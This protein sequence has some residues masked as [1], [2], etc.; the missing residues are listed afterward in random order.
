MYLETILRAV[1]VR[2]HVSRQC[3]IRV[4][5]VTTSAYRRTKS[6]S[7]ANE[8][9]SLNHIT[10]A[11]L[12]ILSEGLRRRARISSLTITAMVEVR[13]HTLTYN[14]GQVWLTAIQAVMAI[15]RQISEYEVE[16]TRLAEDSVAYLQSLG[17]PDVNVEAEFNAIL[18]V[19]KLLLRFGKQNTDW[20]HRLVLGQSIDVSVMSKITCLWRLPSAGCIV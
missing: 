5:N 3:L 14:G 15:F 9:G 12:E 10:I 16:G 1:L 19:S 20:L 6:Q 18:A 17:I 11:F 13:S 4:L 2:F 8:Q 7:S